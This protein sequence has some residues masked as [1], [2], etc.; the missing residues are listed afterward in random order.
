MVQW[1]RIHFP[2]PGTWVQKISPTWLGAT[3]PTHCIYRARVTQQRPRTAKGERKGRWAGE[4]VIGACTAKCPDQQ[5]LLATC[6]KTRSRPTGR[7]GR[8]WARHAQVPGGGGQQETVARVDPGLKTT[9]K[10][11]FP[12]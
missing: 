5:E 7:L 3:K 1:S 6:A 2:M 4:Q 9:C 10:A 11:N 12:W 8:S